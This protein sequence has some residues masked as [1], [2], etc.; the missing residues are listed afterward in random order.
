MPTG[1]IISA[2]YDWDVELSVWWEGAKNNKKT[3][4]TLHSEIIMH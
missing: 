3:N 1:E 2:H 4:T